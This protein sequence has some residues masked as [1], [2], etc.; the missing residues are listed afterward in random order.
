[1]L[2]RHD[3]VADFGC[4][5]SLLARWALARFEQEQLV[6]IGLGALDARA[7]DRFEPQVWPDQEVRVRDEPAYATEPVHGPGG[8]VQELHDLV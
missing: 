3:V 1:V 2:H 4:I 7:E 8:L 6:D 5:V